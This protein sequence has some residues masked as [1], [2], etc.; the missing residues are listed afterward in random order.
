MRVA[1]LADGYL[2][3]VGGGSS[4][5]ASWVQALPEVEFEILTN[6][7][8]GTP[9]V[10]RMGGNCTVRRFLPTDLSSTSLNQ[11]FL[12]PAVFPYKLAS[13]WVRFRRKFDY[14][15]RSGFD[16]VHFNGPIT[17]YAFF[18][19][20]RVLGRPFLTARLD[21]T[22]LSMAKVLTLHGLPSIST[23]SRV[24]AENERRQVS[25]FDSVV[26]VDRYM[27]DYVQA[28]TAGL[29]DRPTVHFIPNGIDTAAFPYSAPSPATRLR[30][31]F[32]GRL[33]EAKG[34]SLLLDVARALPP[35]VEFALALAGRT[36][37]AEVRLAECDRVTLQRNVSP[38]QVPGFLSS[39]HVLLNPVLVPGISRATLEAMSVGRPV[40]MPPVGDRYPVMDGDTGFL[41]PPIAEPVL[42][43]LARLA[44]EPDALERMGRKASDVIRREFDSRAMASR[45]LAVF[46][47][48]IGKRRSYR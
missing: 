28:I 18:A 5:I 10:E 20:D 9:Q 23:R 15:G 30:V 13:E 34:A 1:E 46:R 43:L 12:K 37:E 36:S 11:A 6:H 27:T 2:P 3:L 45:L 4:A 42:S 32:L 39:I 19:V 29:A 16:V 35:G 26:V 8:P 44:R 47:E 38:G 17:N 14:L 33:D 22:R 7:V 25:S 31:G 48:A 24:D 41:C 21:F 40:I